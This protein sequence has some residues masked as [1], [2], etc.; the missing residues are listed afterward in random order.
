MEENALFC[1]SNERNPFHKKVHFPANAFPSKSEEEE[2]PQN[3]AFLEPVGL[4]HKMKIE[5]EIEAD[6]WPSIAKNCLDE[7]ALTWSREY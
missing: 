2:L 3:C 6:R 1:G 5:S 7:E 4:L